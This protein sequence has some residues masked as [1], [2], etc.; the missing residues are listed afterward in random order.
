MFKLRL[1]DPLTEGER[2]LILPVGHNHIRV[3]EI[4]T[5]D[6]RNNH[7][8]NSA[9]TRKLLLHSPHVPLI[10]PTTLQNGAGG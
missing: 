10:W 5:D 6:L 7:S 9:P 8:F 4:L 2:Y 3:S 1:V